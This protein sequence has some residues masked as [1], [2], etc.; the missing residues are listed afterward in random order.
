MYLGTDVTGTT[1][2]RRDGVLLGNTPSPVGVTVTVLEELANYTVTST[3]TREAGWTP[4]GTK[5]ETTWT[6]RSGL[7]R[8]TGRLLSQPRH[9]VDL[10][11]ALEAHRVI[12]RQSA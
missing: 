9:V 7:E 5:D 2:V 11:F 3:A 6:F 4:V 1:T 10:S 12:S 8:L